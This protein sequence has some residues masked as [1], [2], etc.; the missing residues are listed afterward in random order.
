MTS[1]VMN[2][3]G[4]M[5]I[6]VEICVPKNGTILRPSVFDAN[7]EVRYSAKTIANLSMSR[8]AIGGNGIKQH[9]TCSL[10]LKQGLFD[11]ENWAAIFLHVRDFLGRKSLE[12]SPVGCGAFR[13]M[14][15]QFSAC[16]R[17]TSSF[18][19]TFPPY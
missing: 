18:M 3:N 8:S 13:N 4:N 16:L 15:A 17:L 2:T 1:V 5:K 12:S 19:L 7:R 9:C 6:A 14:A 11:A 10:N